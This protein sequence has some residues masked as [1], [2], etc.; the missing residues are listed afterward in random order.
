MSYPSDRRGI[1][2]TEEMIQQI[3]I[4]EDVQL[5]FLILPRVSENNKLLISLDKEPTSV[6]F[7][8]AN[9]NYFHLNKV[10][11]SAIRVATPDRSKGRKRRKGFS[12]FY[13]GSP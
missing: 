1:S 11:K 9:L 3:D 8:S 6:F 2:E 4:I 13:L 7:H 5:W 12:Y 10:N